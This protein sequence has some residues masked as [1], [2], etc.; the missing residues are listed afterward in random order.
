MREALCL[1]AAPRRQCRDI[2][3]AAF[4][5]ALDLASEEAR[6][7]FATVFVFLHAMRSYPS[8][9]LSRFEALGTRLVFTED[10]QSPWGPGW[11][12][13]TGLHYT[14]INS[15]HVGLHSTSL[16]S[17]PDF[18]I[19]VGSP[20]NLPSLH[21]PHNLGRLPRECTTVTFSLPTGHSNGFISSPFRENLIPTSYL[22]SLYCHCIAI[23]LNCLTHGVG[24]HFP[25]PDI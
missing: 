17:E 20:L 16:I 6:N 4:K 21:V 23:Y 25:F 13:S 14:N 9:E 19:E 18:F 8:H 3:E 12:Y 24:T 15:T 22:H 5:L 10:K 2:N 1:P 7:R 11:E